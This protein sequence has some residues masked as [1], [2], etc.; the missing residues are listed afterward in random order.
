MLS[1]AAAGALGG[2]LVGRRE[3]LRGRTGRWQGRAAEA[4]VPRPP[5]AGVPTR[6]A[7]AAERERAERRRIAAEMKT[8]PPRRAPDEHVVPTVRGA[9]HAPDE[10]LYPQS[11]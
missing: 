3:V 5:R 6:F 8:H 10:H 7:D 4:G 2:F 9:V 11:L 1:A